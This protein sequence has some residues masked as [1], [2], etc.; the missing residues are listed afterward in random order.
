MTKFQI[1]ATSADPGPWT[2]YGVVE[3]HSAKQAMTNWYMRHTPPDV[4]AV[5]AVP[6]RSWNPQKIRTE[7]QTKVVLGEPAPVETP[8]D[9]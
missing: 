3:A 9:A 1:L 4:V 7:T 5:V 8:G 2:P 6:V